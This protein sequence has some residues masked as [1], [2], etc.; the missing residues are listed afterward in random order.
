M[1]KS[2]EINPKAAYELFLRSLKMRGYI[3]STRIRW[4]RRDLPSFGGTDASDKNTNL[5][6]VRSISI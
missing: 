2:G 5:E 4:K 1:C 3:S 6:A